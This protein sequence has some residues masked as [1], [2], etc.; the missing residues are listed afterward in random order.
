M[1]LCIKNMISLLIRDLNKENL[2]EKWSLHLKF[3]QLIKSTREITSKNGTTDKEL[4]MIESG[5]HISLS[6]K[7][8][9][10]TRECG[11]LNYLKLTLT[12][13]D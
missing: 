11:H 13:Q 2:W 10:Q 3:T 9:E 6:I 4:S 12:L 1:E 7:P 8:K 5:L